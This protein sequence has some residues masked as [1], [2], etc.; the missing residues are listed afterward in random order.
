MTQLR[1]AEGATGRVLAAALV[2]AGVLLLP[3][4]LRPESAAAG[5][6]A[7]RATID[8]IE[9]AL[10]EDFEVIA[11][12]GRVTRPG[13]DGYGREFLSLTGPAL[14]AAG[15]AFSD[16]T[17]P[18]DLTGTLQSIDP[19]AIGAIYLEFEIA[20]DSD[21]GTRGFDAYFFV[22]GAL[23]S[24]LWLAPSGQLQTTPCDG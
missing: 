11:V 4:C 13:S 10:C 12:E 23:S 16:G 6:A 22:D 7:I 20:D 18:P 15:T 2:M 21:D 5:P 19:T 9:I 17:L 24:E 14:I 1:V 3:G 8:G